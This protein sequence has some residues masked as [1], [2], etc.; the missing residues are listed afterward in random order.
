MHWFPLLLVLANRQIVNGDI[1]ELYKETKTE[2]FEERPLSESQTPFFES[3]DGVVLS[4][5]CDLCRH[6][7]VLCMRIV[8]MRIF[9]VGVESTGDFPCLFGAVF[10]DK[11]GMSGECWSR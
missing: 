3:G 7:S 5:E 6:L 4:F 1:P 10:A 2:A 8:V 9:L 11:P